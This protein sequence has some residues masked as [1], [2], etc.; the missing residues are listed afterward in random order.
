MIE[1]LI[2]YTP[3]SSLIFV[4]TIAVSLYGIYGDQHGNRGLMLH[5]YSIHRGK[6]YFPFVLIFPC[7]G[8]TNEKIKIETG[9]WNG[10]DG[11]RG[12]AVP[13]SFQRYSEFWVSILPTALIPISGESDFPKISGTIFEIESQTATYELIT[14]QQVATAIAKSVAEKKSDYWAVSPPPQIAVQQS[15]PEAI[16]PAKNTADPF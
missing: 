4:F 7:P 11:I 12:A 13:N 9:T 6:K 16:A 1:D 15:L 2:R 10:R 14:A 3:I 8:D 5:P